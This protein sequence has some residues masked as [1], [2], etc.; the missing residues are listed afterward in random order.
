MKLLVIGTGN[1]PKG[2]I[3]QVDIWRVWRPARE[4]AKNVDW[5]IDQRPTI[6]KQFAKYKKKEDFTEEEL[7]ATV[8]DLKQYDVIYGSYTSFLHTMVFSLCMMMADKYGT[9]IVIDVDDN[10]FAIKPDNIGWWYAMGHEDTWVLQTIVLNAP[11]ITTTNDHLAYELRKRRKQPED[12]VKIVPNYISYDYK[13][14]KKHDKLT[15]G[16]FGGASHHNDLHKTGVTKAIEKLMHEYKDIEFKS[17]GMEIKDYL[18]RARYEFIG[19]QKGHLWTKK[20][21]PSL[22]FD[23]AIAPLTDDIFNKSKSDIK[24][25]E[26]AMMG[27]AFIGSLA[28]P[29]LDTVE[30]GVDGLLV[31]NTTEKWYEALKKLV[32]DKKLRDKLVKNAQAKVEKDYM[33]ENKWT[34]LKEALESI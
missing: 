25:Q 28:R 7:V 23:I 14:G 20:L 21:F 16:Y 11:Y 6:M 1:N 30:N 13:A 26:S 29:Y 8:E 15:I 24:W 3:H 12:T 10:M 5:Q 31:E 19:G 2:H 33:I 22:N 4:L 34:A 17:V 9:K 27:A 18:P 32:D